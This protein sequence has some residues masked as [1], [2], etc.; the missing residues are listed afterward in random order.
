[1]YRSLLRA[2]WLASPLIHVPSFS[3]L[4]HSMFL[5]LSAVNSL[6]FLVA[7]GCALFVMLLH[8]VAQNLCIYCG[9]YL[10]KFPGGMG[11]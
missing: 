9:K 6:P 2:A 8:F 10:Y 1:M 7:S 4:N 3:L 11:K 5:P